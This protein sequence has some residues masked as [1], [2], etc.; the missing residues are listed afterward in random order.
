MYLKRENEKGPTRTLDPLGL[1]DENS[2][3]EQT[4][5]SL[6]DRGLDLPLEERRRE[7]EIADELHSGWRDGQRAVYGESHSRE[8]ELASVATPHF[9]QI[10]DLVGKL[11]FDLAE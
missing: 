11:S 9:A 8:A 2:S 10:V 7:R 1:L 5:R 3:G 4:F 6:P